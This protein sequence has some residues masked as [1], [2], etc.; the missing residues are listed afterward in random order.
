MD[1]VSH[2]V[3][4]MNDI[5]NVEELLAENRRRREINMRIYDPIRGDLEDPQRFE[6]PIEEEPGGSVFLPLE[7]R[8]ETM[9]RELQRHGS[10][11]MYDRVVNRRRGRR[12]EPGSEKDRLHIENVRREFTLL[13][14]RYDFPFWAASFVYIKVKGGGESRRFVLNAPQRKLVES[15]E[16]MRRMGEP[17]RLILLKAR[18]WGGSTCVQLYMAWLQ[19][20]QE[21]SL[22]SLIIAHQRA[23]TD[24]ILEMFTH[25]LER[26]PD[27]LLESLRHSPEGQGETAGKRGRRGKERRIE[28]AGMSRSAFRIPARNCKVKVGSAE[29]PDACRGGDYNLVHF[30][31]VGLWKATKGKTPEMVVRSACSGVLLRHNTMIVMEST[32]NGTGNYFHTEYSAAK[33]GESQFKALFVAWYE[34]DQ[35][36]TPIEDEESFA[37]K[38]LE[39]RGETVHNSMRRETGAYLWSL[40]QRGATLEAIN[41]YVNERMKYNDHGQMAAEYP[42]DDV[43]AFVHSGARVFDQYN[44][45]R[46]RPDC[47]MPPQIGEIMGDAPFGE[48]ALQ[49]LR[50]VPSE[51][52]CLKMWED[53]GWTPR[54]L[55]MSDRYLVVVDIGGR[56]RTSDWSVILVIDREDMKD[57][58]KPRIVAQW[59]GHT[60]MYTLAWKAASIAKYYHDALLVVESNTIETCDPYRRVDGDQSYSIFRE[61]SDVNINLYERHSSSDCIRETLSNRY[62]FHTNINTK[63]MI[64]SGLIKAVNEQM[65]IER[66]EECLDEYLTYEQRQNGSFG[67]IAGKHDDLLMTRAIGLHVCFNEMP[68]PAIFDCRWFESDKPILF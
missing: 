67:A 45:E 37:A 17:I 18:Q 38:L 35:Y 60:E 40:W 27:W 11:R 52:G 15:L 23:G 68:L 1:Y 55:V 29:R 44:V 33:R 34:I 16:S 30:S 39:G 28:A 25:M 6:L 41:W 59:R 21:V 22:N 64:I 19:L 13:R 31:E 63:P 50:F 49:L 62:G 2:D 3:S 14:I 26:Y 10:Y 24:E 12:A 46:M 47:M 42:S 58:G 9:V 43:E 53:R 56:C 36:S 51:R 7:M 54:H 4:E 32:A 8:E 5:G 65:Y 61:L 20:V 48:R 57:G 66:D